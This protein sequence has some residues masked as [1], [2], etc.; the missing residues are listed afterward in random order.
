MTIL[1]LPHTSCRPSQLKYY[2]LQRGLNSF[3]H[4]IITSHVFQISL[5]YLY[6][7]PRVP[8][9]LFSMMITSCVLQTLKNIHLLPPRCSSPESL[10]CWRSWLAPSSGCTRPHRWQ[11]PVTR[12]HGVSWCVTRCF[13]ILVLLTLFQNP[14]YIYIWSFQWMVKNLSASSLP[15]LGPICCWRLPWGSWQPRSDPPHSPC[16]PP[17]PLW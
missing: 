16:G 13:K 1:V 4:F 17:N 14:C 3:H 5:S 8:D 2:H 15:S 10:V 6:F 9:Y 11:A 12:S 7:L